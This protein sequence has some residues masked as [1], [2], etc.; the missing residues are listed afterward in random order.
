[1]YLVLIN[2]FE[3]GAVVATFAF[4]FL[5]LVFITFATWKINNKPSM[6]LKIILFVCFA[7][8]T[9]NQYKLVIK[10]EYYERLVA[11]DV[12]E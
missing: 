2:G 11:S 8:L 12:R 5:V 10:A 3:Y 4:M 7:W 6:A 9:Y 1:M